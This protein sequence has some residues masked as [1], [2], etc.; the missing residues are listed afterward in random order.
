MMNAATLSFDAMPATAPARR[1]PRASFDADVFWNAVLGRSRS[2]DGVFYYGVR[3]TGIYCRPSCPS[4]R[5]RR[6]HVDFFLEPQEA[7]SAGFRACLRCRPAQPVSQSPQAELTRRVCRYIEDNL[8]ATLTLKTMAA[9]IGGSPFHLQRVFQQAIGVTPQQYAEARRIAV[10]KTA[11]RFGENVAE[12]GY[13]AGFGSSRGLYERAGSHLGMT[14]ATY[15]KG[16]AGQHITYTIVESPLGRMLVAATAKGICKISLG[17]EGSDAEMSA[18]LFR[19][20]PK[21]RIEKADTSAA[22]RS[23]VEKIVEHLHDFGSAL[24]LPLDLRATAFQVRV[25]RELKKIPL[26]QTRSYEEIARRIKQP[27]AT[28]AVAR[29]CAS[30]PVALAIPCHRVVRKD[31]AMGGY[32]WGVERKKALLASEFNARNARKAR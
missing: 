27:S 2:L 30:N 8:E 14:P 4:R 23:A 26:G 9:E 18:A 28:R 6:E 16:A 11:L 32:R 1:D 21:A 22:L 25:W 15:R 19:E 17:E 7:E 13:T 3:S 29:A 5:P 31:G 24:D 12:A 20:Y 10:F